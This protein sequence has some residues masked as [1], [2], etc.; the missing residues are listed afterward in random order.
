MRGATP[1]LA[2]DSKRPSGDSI[3]TSIRSVQ[4]E[5]VLALE[6]LEPVRG[7]SEPGAALLD[8]GNDT[9]LGRRGAPPTDREEVSRHHT[10]SDRVDLD[11][12]G[13]ERS[14]SRRAETKS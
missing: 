9:R 1:L 8:L 12:R 11:G 4:L 3:C 13:W 7:R 14:S 5:A 10:V 2:L 6:L